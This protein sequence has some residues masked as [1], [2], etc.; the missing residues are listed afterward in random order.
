M[1]KMGNY[2]PD[3]SGYYDVEKTTD[4]RV[5]ARRGKYLGTKS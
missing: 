3:Y 2:M 5:L 4:T 1:A